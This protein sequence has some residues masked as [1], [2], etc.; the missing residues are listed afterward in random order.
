MS[1]KI[2]LPVWPTA[3][4]AIQ[5]SADNR[6]AVLGGESIAILTPR[7]EPTPDG[8]FWDTLIIRIN[9]FTKAEIPRYLPVP[10]DIWSLGEEISINTAHSATW[11]ALGLA[12]YGTCALGVLTTNHVLSI[13]APDRIPFPSTQWRRE[14]VINHAVQEFYKKRGLA[15]VQ[16]VQ[17]IQAFAW[18]R[19]W[20]PTVGIASEA[21]QRTSH[22]FIAVATHGGHILFMQIRSPMREIWRT[23]MKWQATICGHLD[24]TANDDTEMI[25]VDDARRSSRDALTIET[26]RPS[27]DNIVWSEWSKDNNTSTL[28]FI[29]EGKLFG[30]ELRFSAL[31]EVITVASAELGHQPRAILDER[32]DIHAPLSFVGDSP[33]NSLIVFGEDS[34]CQFDCNVPQ[35]SSSS[36]HLDGRWDTISGLAFTEHESDRDQG[37]L[38]RMHFTSHVSTLSSATANLVLPMHNEESSAESETTW[39]QELRASRDAFSADKSLG[40]PRRAD[41]GLAGETQYDTDTGVQERVWGIASSPFSNYVATCVTFHPSETLEYAIQ[42]EQMTTVNITPEAK[43][44]T[45]SPLPSRARILLRDGKATAETIAFEIVRSMERRASDPSV[46]MWEL[47]NVVESIEGAIPSLETELN[48]QATSTSANDLE[49]TPS[50]IRRYLKNKLILASKVKKLR[51]SRL[52]RIIIA[53]H[54]DQPLSAESVQREGSLNVEMIRI[55]IEA[56]LAMP[57]YEKPAGVISE[58]DPLGCLIRNVYGIILGKLNALQKLQHEEQANLGPRTEDLSMRSEYCETCNTPIKFESLKWARCSNPHHVHQFS[59]CALTFLAIQ[60]PQ[61]EQMSMTK[62]CGLC[63]LKFISDEA[64][65]EL[66]QRPSRT[67]VRGPGDVPLQ[68]GFTNLDAGAPANNQNLGAHSARPGLTPADP[69]LVENNI[70]SNPREQSTSHVG[71][72]DSSL[73]SSSPSM[74]SLAI[75]MY[76]TCSVCFYCGGQY[77]D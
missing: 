15:K 20:Y 30:I 68:A 13:W 71:K 28:A 51:T 4:E 72:L 11:S 18:S 19:P 39:K 73:K 56:V 75:A 27:A 26:P 35:S 1:C 57:N 44:A 64:I 66:S 62:S 24:A 53:S 29:V 67:Q 31:G 25:D 65:C 38:I 41:G 23:D 2:I 50:N 63:E 16:A 43:S 59:R 69:E 76:A 3:L 14:I 58:E 40:Y 52:S 48:D 70:G 32:S 9:G 34:V 61:Q 22:H 47:A 12:K 42:N 17:R 77:T 54:G 55:L 37:R 74:N 45:S 10:D 6:I 8:A 5:W 60:Q 49:R 33:S 21:E 36:H 7:L 46:P